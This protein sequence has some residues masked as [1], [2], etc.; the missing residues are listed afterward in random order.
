MTINKAN[1]WSDKVQSFSQKYNIPIEYLAEILLDPKVIPMIRGKAFEYSVLIILSNILNKKE[2]QVNK[3]PMNAQ[4]ELHDEDITVTHI[5]S[6]ARI[7][8]ECKLAKKQGYSSRDG[9]SIKVKCMRS[10]TLGDEKIKNL[11]PRL[12]LSEAVLKTHNDQYVDSNFDFVVTSIGNA[13]Y[14]TDKS[15][16][17]YE[18]KP[19]ENELK[20]LKALYPS[21]SEDFNNPDF[22]RD[23]A[24]RKIYIAK[25]KDLTI[26]STNGITCTRKKCTNKTDCN[27]IP[28]YP[29]I[30]FNPETY[31]PFQPWYEIEDC[32]NLFSSFIVKS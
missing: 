14:R 31:K 22:Q 1:L 25:S 20:F 3:V 7:R 15:T 21:L 18:W 6:S 19:T 11:A 8:I 24:F 26:N 12:G 10:R 5:A 17:L 2:W 28:N 30:K 29:I 32:P 16:G 27:F 23:L 13:F 9:K 4:Y